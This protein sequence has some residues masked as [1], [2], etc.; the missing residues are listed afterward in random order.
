MPFRTIENHEKIIYIC[1]MF[2]LT[3]IGF[4]ADR[5]RTKEITAKDGKDFIAVQ[6]KLE[7]DE[8][9]WKLN[10]VSN[11]FPLTSWEV[12]TANGNFE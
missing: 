1:T 3:T 11:C 2:A 9:S 4:S 8:A 5:Y 6:G 7:F 12:D 10:A